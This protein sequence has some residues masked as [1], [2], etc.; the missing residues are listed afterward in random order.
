MEKAIQDAMLSGMQGHISKPIIVDIFYKKLFDVLSQDLKKNKAV[1]VKSVSFMPESKNEFKELSI[2]IGLE[3]CNND[4]EF[5]KSLLE[6]F[7]KMYQNSPE[8]LNLMYGDGDFQE[9]RRVAM[10]IKDVALN[11][12]ANNLCES[13]AALEYEFEK[14]A[15]GNGDKLIDFYADNL[16]KLFKDIDKYIEKFC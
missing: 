3:R 1:D 2:S 4:K 12:G 14:G 16:A 7:K 10:D 9:A 15:R 13:A 11:I 8:L 5:Y 6:E